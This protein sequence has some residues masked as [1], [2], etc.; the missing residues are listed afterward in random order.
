MKGAVVV[1]MVSALPPTV[2]ALL[3]FVQ[4]RAAQRASAAE[5]TAGITQTVEILG[6]GIARLEV[7]V[8]R[9]DEGVTDLRERVARLEGVVSGPRGLGAAG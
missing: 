4:A 8:G 1:A 2:A 5:R 9:V 7:T 3:A 6:G